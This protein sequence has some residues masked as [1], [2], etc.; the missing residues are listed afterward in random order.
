MKVSISVRVNE[1]AVPP[2]DGFW[3]TPEFFPPR[4]RE[5]YPI[6][7]KAIELGG[8]PDVFLLGEESNHTN[9]HAVRMDRHGQWFCANLMALSEYGHRMFNLDGTRS[10]L[11]TADQHDHIVRAYTGTYS[12]GVAFWNT[13]GTGY[14]PNS[15]PLSNW[16]AG[17]NLESEDPGF[18]AIR[19]TGSN[20]HN[21]TIANTNVC[22]DTWHLAN[23]E[24]GWENNI[25]YDC[26]I[27]IL[28][29]RRICW[30][31]IIKAG[32]LKDPDFPDGS[33]A[34]NRFPRLTKGVP[35]PLITR[36]PV[37]YPSYLLLAGYKKLYWP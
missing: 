2:Q 23:T 34:V 4:S 24:Y 21:G 35:I 8:A 20:V 22:I 19:T 31:T 7:P 1:P 28:T 25:P 36:K 13:R 17:E 6:R 11:L 16:V 12:A 30:A 10:G 32:D 15:V 18:D 26:D 5:F 33:F 27:D 14:G 3:V 9:S 37:F 29:D